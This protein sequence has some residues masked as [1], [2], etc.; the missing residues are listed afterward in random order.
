MPK[1]YLKQ[2]TLCLCSIVSG[3]VFWIIFFYYRFATYYATLWLIFWFK[4]MVVFIK[5][6][7][8]YG[9]CLWYICTHVAFVGF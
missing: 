4:L 8:S 7:V 1:T 9:T 3:V 6:F 5:T 2:F